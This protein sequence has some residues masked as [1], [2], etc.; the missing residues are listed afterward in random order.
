MCGVDLFYDMRKCA[1]GGWLKNMLIL[2]GSFIFEIL[3]VC[4]AVS[5]FEFFHV[6]AVRL[7]LL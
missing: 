3:F 4:C 5:A 6:V 1:F 2:N 7:L